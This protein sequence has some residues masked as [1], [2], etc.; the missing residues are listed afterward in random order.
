MY[1]TIIVG[2]GPA[3]LSAAISAQQLGLEYLVLERGVIAD[4]IYR[5]PIARTLFSTADELQLEPGDLA[6]KHKPTREELLNHYVRI[7]CREGLNI[8]TGSDVLNVSQRQGVFEV[9]ATTGIYSART[10]LIAV[11]GF[12]RQRRL[13]V[14]GEDD[15]RVS[16][17]FSEA[18]PF[19][20][21][22][23]LIV[24]GGNSAAEAAI[25]LSEV[26][27]RVT[28][29]VRR[30]SLEMDPDG[31]NA[32]SDSVQIKPWVRQPLDRAISEGLIRLLTGARVTSIGPDSATVAFGRLSGDQSMVAEEVPCN[33][34][35]ALIGADPDTH[36]LEQ[37]G[38]AIG[39]DGRPVYDTETY[40]TSVP[41]LYVAGHL[42]REKHIKAAISVSRKVI[43]RIAAQILAE[44]PA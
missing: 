19:A 4:T 43:E 32:H 31:E 8:L 41:G 11:G 29:A 27:A 37:A 10:L 18:H 13:G 33:H 26:G 14:P 16:Y 44:C 23:V 9:L 25:W 36:L 1:D 24:G 20:M 39:N 17:R 7:A 22:D 34:I 42:T 35:F 5:F 21:K 12:G 2:G 38:A 30:R 6:P 3:G 28:M 15:S 40:E